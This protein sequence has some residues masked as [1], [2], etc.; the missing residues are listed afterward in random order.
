MAQVAFAVA[1]LPT[2]LFISGTLI[3]SGLADPGFAAHEFLA[4]EVLLDDEVPPSATADAYRREF[5]SRYEARVG[6][7]MQR[8]RAEPDV[9]NVT[10]TSRLPGEEA[11]VWIDVDGITPPVGVESNFAVRRGL[12]AGHEVAMARVDAGFLSTLGVPLL[13]G[14][15]LEPADAGPA[16][17]AVVANRVFVE[18]VFGEDSPLGRRFRYI[19][20]SGNAPADLEL[21][22]SYEIV[23][24]VGNLPEESVEALEEV[25]AKVYHAATPGQA[26]PVVLAIH[27]RGAGPAPFTNR[28]RAIAAAL[29]PTLRLERVLPIDETYKQEQGAARMAAVA[30]VVVM[31]SV[32][33]LVSAGLYALM[34][35]AVIQRRREIGIRVAIGAN[36]RRILGSIFS[37][38][39]RQLAAG[40]AIGVVAAAGLDYI[41][42]GDL[43]AGEGSRPAAGRLSVD[44]GRG[45]AVGARPGPARSQDSTDRSA[46]D[47]TLTFTSRCRAADST[48]SRSAPS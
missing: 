45:T 25:E 27:V 46:E 21:G 12:G 38:T 23:G 24:V 13:A 37:R 42:G 40:I 2:A 29:D 22:R 1:I 11:T 19:G 33:L 32:L 44:A 18:Y 26:Y 8:L 16:S 15:A 35:F 28:L 39:L 30:I 4:A 3:G 43:L 31:V 14:R 7:M 20:A 34:S 41:S 47:R 17:T 48:W 6:E 5:T 10:F 9:S 36:P